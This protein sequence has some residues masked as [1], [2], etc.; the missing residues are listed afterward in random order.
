V[1][2]GAGDTDVSGAAAPAT[3]AR[4]TDHRPDIQG[5]RALAVI[6]VVVFHS[7]LALPGGFVGV[8]VFFVISGYL[9]IGLIAREVLTTGSLDLGRF[10]ARRIRRLLPALA[11]MVSCTVLIAAAVVEFGAPLRTVV[12][13]AVGAALFAANGV[14]YVDQDYFAPEAER[15]PLLHTWSLS[16]EEQFYVAV[17]ILLALLAALSRRTQRDRSLATGWR[18]RA[19]TSLLLVSVASF[20]LSVALVDL[21]TAVPGLQEP[22]AFAFYSPFTRAWEFGVGGLLA[23]SGSGSRHPAPRSSMLATFGLGM[24]V[25]SALLLD[26]GSPFPGIRAIPA[27]VGTLLLLSSG[28]R[29]GTGWVRGVLSARP[30]TR[31]GDLS[32]S[33]YLW[34]WPAMV[35]MWAWLGNSPV[36]TLGAVLVSVGAAIFSYERVEQR[37]R[38]D[39]SFSGGRAVRLLAACILLPATI[40]AT[41]GWAN[42]L[43]AERLDLGRSAR[44]WSVAE[45]HFGHSRSEPWPVQRCTRGSRDAAERIDV[46]LLGDSHAASLS[47][48][49]LLATTNL[50]LSLGVWTVSSQPPHGESIWADRY[51]ELVAEHRPRVIVLA[52]RS[53]YYR[54]GGDLDRW[55]TATPIG[56]GAVDHLW[57]KSLET[58][59]ERYQDL[60][61]AIIWVHNVPEFERDPNGRDRGPTLLLPG[62]GARTLSTSELDAQRRGIV[63]LEASA[64]EGRERVVRLDPAE[65]LCTPICTNVGS[66]G[67]LYYD[68]HHLNAT[69]S[70]LLAEAFEQA[71]RE[72][73]GP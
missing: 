44:S 49:L 1:V 16:V 54:D 61:A 10:F 28:E 72:A 37:F 46:L 60:G 70:A 22:M 58:A 38:R 2:G 45:C 50:E 73:L 32:Y 67:F 40:A 52:S 51:F 5:L 56:D 35:L 17:P 34:H 30:L 26:G 6:L 43:L 42:G 57:R 64:L 53:L 3:A 71:I 48:G 4:M 47:D 19:R 62:R 9:I 25:A 8:D 12:R 20:A 55:S 31:T 7:G 39:A 29:I 13:T 21:G 11:L 23:L 18:G 36:V 68:S 24:I 69:G 33:L 15:N 59:V 14:L 66:T 63:E 65:R 41:V 27:V